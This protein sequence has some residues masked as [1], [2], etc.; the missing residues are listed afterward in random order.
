MRR[1]FLQLFPSRPLFP[2]LSSCVILVPTLSLAQEQNV[3]QPNK[4]EAPQGQTVEVK[5]SYDPRRDDTASKFVVRREE[6]IKFG[7]HSLLDVLSRQPGI[8]TDGK[9]ISLNGFGGYTKILVDGLPPAAGRG[10]NDIDPNEVERIEIMRAAV[11]EFS[12]QAIGGVINIILKRKTLE[13]SNKLSYRL[14]KFQPSDSSQNLSWNWQTK[15]DAYSYLQV[16]TA[17][18]YDMYLHSQAS[19]FNVDAKNREVDRVETSGKVLASVRSALFM[20]R[21]DFKSDDGDTISVRLTKIHENQTIKG[22][23]YWAVIRGTPKVVPQVDEKSDVRTS[24]DSRT[25]DWGREISKDF[26]LQSTFTQSTRSKRYAHQDVGWL[27][28][29]SAPITMNSLTIDATNSWISNGSLTNA[30]VDRHLIKLGWEVGQD[31]NSSIFTNDDNSQNSANVRTRNQAWYVQDEWKLSSNWSQYLGIRTEA[32]NTEVLEVGEGKVTN[33]SQTTSPIVQSLWRLN[34][35]NGDQIRFAYARTFKNPS[36]SDLYNPRVIRFNNNVAWTQFVGN[37][38]L[39]PELAHGFDLVFEHSGQNQLNYSANLDTRNIGGL[40]NL[41]QFTQE[42]TWLA[43]QVNDGRAFKRTLGLE[44]SF[45]TSLFVESLR[46]LQFKGSAQQTQASYQSFVADPTLRWTCQT[47]SMKW[48]LDY[49]G[50]DNLKM[51]ASDNFQSA[52]DCRSSPLEW[53]KTSAT[54][55]LDTYVNWN[56]E[57]KLSI[58]FAVKNWLAKNSQ[59]ES[60]VKTDTGYAISRMSFPRYRQISLQL[61]W[62]L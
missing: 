57:K 24:V 9:T 50:N 17:R 29:I 46:R 43:R 28:K 39:Q 34:P 18:A 22:P 33:S 36:V 21:F 53:L 15:G 55:Q 30:S 20:P 27:S 2:L 37:A 14:S 45:P 51:G 32:F 4:T 49:I 47:Y 12:T 5:A 8:T 61:E 58:R 44:V 10:L 60:R 16:V 3:S 41:Q 13:D 26:T 62:N 1:T 23:E 42:G 56:I 35:E 54:H 25:V 31:R 19:V 59:S 11:A 40:L 6:I 48:S 52:S 7:D 38:Q